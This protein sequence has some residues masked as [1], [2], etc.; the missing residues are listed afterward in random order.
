[1]SISQQ[2]HNSINQPGETLQF[3]NPGTGTA[4]HRWRI[5][6][7]QKRLGMKPCFATEQRFLCKKNN[8]PWWDDCQ[9]LRA[10]WAR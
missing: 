10:E 5:W 9:D 1:M 2:S 6:S 3:R 8:C 4:S 7:E